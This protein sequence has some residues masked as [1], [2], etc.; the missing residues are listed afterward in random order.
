MGGGRFVL[1]RWMIV[2][3]RTFG[4]GHF[5]YKTN[6]DLGS[7]GLPPFSVYA[8]FFILDLVLMKC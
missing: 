1:G 8:I 2:S 7:R 3:R 5:F 4:M 6:T